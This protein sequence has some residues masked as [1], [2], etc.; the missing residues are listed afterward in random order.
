MQPFSKED[1]HHAKLS[2]IEINF[3][4]KYLLQESLIEKSYAYE[5]LKHE[6]HDVVEDLNE[7]CEFCERNIKDSPSHFIIEM[8]E[9]RE[10]FIKMVYSKQEEMLKKYIQEEY[11]DNYLLLK[12]NVDKIVPFL[13]AGV[14]KPLGLPDWHGLILG[15]KEKLHTAS[16]KEY[17]EG[18]INSG[19]FLG[20]LDTILEYSPTL[21]T[22]DKMKTYITKKIDSDFN[23][24]VDENKHN[25]RDIMNLASSFILTTNYDNALD[26]YRN[27]KKDGY[28][29][30]KIIGDI[31][32]LQGHFNKGK[33]QV[34]HFHGMAERPKT[35]V[36]TKNDYNDLYE[37]QKT[38]DFLNGIMSGKFLLFIGFSFKDLYFKE[39]YGKIHNSIGGEHFII[40]PN[41]HPRENKQLSLMG[42]TPIGIKVPTESDKFQQGMVDAIK[43]LIN[44]II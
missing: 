12:E 2:E 32:N 44:S 15:M 38:K 20:A 3:L 29:T 27:K 33:K 25:I 30:P 11:M 9:L 37:N 8:F 21:N 5:C 35:M 19:D 1:L 31:E 18:L 17:C 26:V 34:V 40:V 39:I 16:D 13:G 4:M 6:E 10:E 7:D 24:E 41:L 43:Y 42:L 36:V 22:E 23:D 14:S 28:S